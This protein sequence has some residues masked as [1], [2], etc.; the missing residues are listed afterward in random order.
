M[1][2]IHDS[3][4]LNNDAAEVLYH[5]HASDMPIY[6]FHCHLPVQEIAED[7]QYKNA[8]ELWLGGDHYKWRVMR[9]NGAVES[10]VTGKAEDYQKFLRWAESVERA[11]GNPVYHWTHL[12]LKRYFDL[13]TILTRDTAELVW[14]KMNIRISEP[15]FSARQLISA[16]RV[17]HICTTDDPADSLQ[18]HEKLANDDTFHVTVVPAFRPD[19][20]LNIEKQ[21]FGEWVKRLSARCGRE[22]GSFADF[23]EALKERIDAFHA[24]GCRVSDHALDTV[25]YR[26]AHESEAADAFSHAAAGKKL[27][28]AEIEAY[29]TYLLVWLGQQYAERGWVMQLHIGA[30]R[31]VN[32]SMLKKLGPNTGFDAIQD[33]PIAYPLGKLLD[34]MDQHDRLPKTIL[35]CLNPRDNEVLAAL[36]GCFQTDG[37]P[38]KIQFGSAWWFND[39][40]DGMETHM[41]VLA[42]LGLLSRF[43]GMLTDSR[44][45]LSYP[46]HEYF[47]RILCNLIGTWVEAGEVPRDYDLLGNIVRDI[48]YRNAVNYFQIPNKE[49]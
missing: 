47:R 2:F 29:K 22:I 23:L 40:R 13:D 41:R 46:R 45:F 8:A 18:W 20:G 14:K 6:D 10:E 38:G 34:T 33:T 19:P 42:N 16:S 36:I 7:I 4:L 48:S 30:F 28:D 11:V 32:S 35:Y 1:S 39:Q 5:E 44:S 49:A 9:S 43:V 27:T 31:S 25:V 15:D 37:I 21:S 17:S 3:F 26:E 24:L 12:E